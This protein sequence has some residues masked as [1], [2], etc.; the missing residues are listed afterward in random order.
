MRKSYELSREIRGEKMKFKE[1]MLKLYAITNRGVKTDKALYEEIEEALKGGAT[2]LQLREKTL[3]EDDFLKVAINVKKLC[4]RYNIPLIIND[5]VEVALKSGADG[6]HLGVED[7]PVDKIRKIAPD[8]FII[9]ATCKTIEQAKIAECSGADYMGVGAVFPSY[10]KKNAISI[11]KELL[12]DI[13]TCVSIPAVAI[14]GI[15]LENAYE[16]KDCGIKGIAAV[17][18]IFDANDIKKATGDLLKLVEE[19]I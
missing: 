6:V 1:N 5:N 2:I 16:L 15:N 9:G 19:I 14:G 7:A 8:N 12:K 10:T 18:S 13:C 17:S 11:T 4:H 3:L